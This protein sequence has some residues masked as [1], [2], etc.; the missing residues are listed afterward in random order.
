MAS[1]GPVHGVTSLLSTCLR[2]RRQAQRQFYHHFYGYAM[3]VSL[4]YAASREEAEEIVHDS[5]LKV[6]LHVDQ[7]AHLPSFKSW[8]RRILINT[9]IDHHRKNHHHHLN[10][11]LEH[12][13]AS[14][15]SEE[16]RQGLELEEL[17]NV[18]ACLSPGY[19]EVFT[20]Y[21]IQG[22]KHQEIAEQL[23]ISVGTSKSNLA[24][25]RKCLQ[26]TLQRMVYER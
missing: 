7:Q 18:I 9:A 11:V 20:R 8:M 22:Y 1:A 13:H 25:A 19:R 23:G 14:V 6:F 24:K 4:R 26:R 2:Q 17:L 15:P 16:N 5:F 21:A 3:G 12:W 10:Q